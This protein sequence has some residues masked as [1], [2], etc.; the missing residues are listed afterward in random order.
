MLLGLLMI[1]VGGAGVGLGVASSVREH[2]ASRR[3][4]SPEWQVRAA[5]QQVNQITLR[6]QKVQLQQRF[7]LA[8][9]D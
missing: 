4:A 9:L 3:E 6:R 2:F 1:G 5:R 7:R 8:P